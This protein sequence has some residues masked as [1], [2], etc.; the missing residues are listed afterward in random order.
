MY[1]DD[2]AK[3]DV[4]KGLNKPAVVTMERIFKIDK[5]TGRPTAD[6][7]AID[8]CA[9]AAP[10]VHAVMRAAEELFAGLAVRA[11]N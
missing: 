9:P 3:P 2:E 8:R 10:A 5:D 1:L 4:G 7:E 6:A 11:H